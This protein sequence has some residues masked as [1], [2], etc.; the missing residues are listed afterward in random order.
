MQL[1]GDVLPHLAAHLVVVGTDEGGVFLGVGLALKDNDGNASVVG[2]VDGGGDG[3]YL[4]GG[5]DE[6]VDARRHKTVNL[7]HLT[8]VVVVGCR[9]AQLNV[10]VEVGGYLQL[11]IL[12]LAPNVL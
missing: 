1:S 8:F 4:V 10:I 7:L 12:L 11:R 9:K 2:A 5:Y 6:Q 3:G